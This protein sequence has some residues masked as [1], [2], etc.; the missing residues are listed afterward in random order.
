VARHESEGT[1]RTLLGFASGRIEMK[2]YGSE[3]WLYFDEVDVAVD[4]RRRGAGRAVM[5]K[6]FGIARRA[7]CV[8]VWLGTSE[9][10]TF[11]EFAWALDA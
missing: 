10:E 2:P 8:E 6:L 9:R 7:G 11:V 4:Q 5:T 1:E 3:Q